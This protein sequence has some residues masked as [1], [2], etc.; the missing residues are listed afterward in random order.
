MTCNC[1]K[2]L[3]LKI[4]CLTPEV[5]ELWEAHKGQHHEGD[6][7]L[8]IPMPFNFAIHPHLREDG[9]AFVVELGIEIE[10]S[11]AYDI[12]P[13]SSISKTPLR[14]ANSIGIIDAGY[15][16]ELKA[17]FDNAGFYSYQIYRGQRLLQIVSP[18]RGPI[19]FELVDELSETS[20]GTG[21]MGSTGR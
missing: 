15:R 3:H 19:T 8:D 13:R 2:G 7:G 12:V 18:D 5:R 20:R 10:P 1:K 9:M 4:K 21:G 14:M 6:A 16:G 11:R 17:P